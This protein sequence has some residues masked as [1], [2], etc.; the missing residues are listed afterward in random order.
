MASSISSSSASSSIESLDSFETIEKEEG[1]VAVIDPKSAFQKLAELFGSKPKDTVSELRERVLVRDPKTGSI[2]EQ[3]TGVVARGRIFPENSLRR[4][5]EIRHLHSPEA[6]EAHIENISTHVIP[7]LTNRE[8]FSVHRSFSAIKRE[9]SLEDPNFVEKQKLINKAEEQLREKI[10]ERGAATDTSDW[11]KDRTISSEKASTT[12]ARKP[13]NNPE[14]KGSRYKNYE[15]SG[16][17]S[18]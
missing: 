5:L 13:F 9:L 17:Y 14:S 18:G 16:S 11:P 15:V 7:L 1:L 6:L 10:S 3:K 2:T 8:L 4:L 12:V